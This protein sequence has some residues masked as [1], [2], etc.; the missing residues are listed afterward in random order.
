MPREEPMWA[1]SGYASGVCA[2]NRCAREKPVFCPKAAEKHWKTE[3]GRTV[4]I[5]AVF[6]VEMPYSDARIPSAR[7]TKAAANSSS[8]TK[9]QGRLEQSLIDSSELAAP[10]NGLYQ[11][12]IKNVYQAREVIEVEAMGYKV[13]GELI[14]F[15]MEWVNHP[16]SGQSQKSP[17]CFGAPAYPGT[18]EGRLHAWRTCLIIFPE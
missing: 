15:F 14:D 3:C 4:I 16:S 1:T 13:L 10:L 18:T 6:S 11:Y 9:K 12:A 8:L 17:S 2:R 5:A 7:P